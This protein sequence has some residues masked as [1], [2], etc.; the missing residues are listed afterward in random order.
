VE[1]HVREDRIARVVRIDGGGGGDDA[2]AEVLVEIAVEVGILEDGAAKS[3]VVE[4]LRLLDEFRCGPR[5]G[6]T[7]DGQ[8]REE[9]EGC[10]EQ[11]ERAGTTGKGVGMRAG[12]ACW[13]M[14]C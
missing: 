10:E 4:V 11:E 3:D 14:R 8:E 1:L 7:S 13:L 5:T 2:L 12:D 9:Q 6:L